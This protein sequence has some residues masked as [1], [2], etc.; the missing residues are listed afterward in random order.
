MFTNLN[1]IVSIR[2]E[3][4][5]KIE[6]DNSEDCNEGAEIDFEDDGNQVTPGLV[7]LQ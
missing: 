2:E 1:C 3:S 6:N 5:K 7:G 4:N